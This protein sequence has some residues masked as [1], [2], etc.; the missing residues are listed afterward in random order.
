M[1]KSF[2]DYGRLQAAEKFLEIE[3]IPAQPLRLFMPRA[4]LTGRG[5]KGFLAF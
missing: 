4:D 2:Q 5:K 3:A 1:E